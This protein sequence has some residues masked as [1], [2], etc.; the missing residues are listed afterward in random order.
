VFLF[1][2][3]L[4]SKFDPKKALNFDELLEKVEVLLENNG[5]VHFEG[6]LDNC[7]CSGSPESD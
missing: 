1:K 3:R 6:F 5:F 4:L 2:K 7:G